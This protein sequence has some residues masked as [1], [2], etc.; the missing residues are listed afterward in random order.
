M[1][2]LLIAPASGK[3]RRVG[4]KHWFNGRTFRFSLLSLLSVAAETPSDV[5]VRIVD[6]QIEKVPWDD[7]FDLVGITCMTAVAPRSYEIAERFRKRGIP[8]VLGGMHPTLCTEEAARH[9]HAVV[10]GDAEGVWP[11]IVADAQAGRLERIYRNPCA[12]D[13]K[14]LKRPPRALL[15]SRRYAT[16]H[17]VQA[18]RGCPH[19]CGFCAV[20]AFHGATQ[21]QRPVE[22]VV[23]EVAEI[24]GR[25]F[26]FADDNLTADREYAR[27]LFEALVPL[28]KRWM[29][30]ST[31]AITEEPGLVRL[32]ARAGCMGM[33]V[34]L[35]SF[36][37]GNLGAV[38]KTCHRV[39]QYRQAVR[40]LHSHGI[41]VEAGIVFGFDGDG[42]GVFARTL[43]L[44]DDLEIDVIQASILTPLPGTG[45]FEDMRD[46]VVDPDWSHYDFHHVVFQPRNLSRDALQAGHDWVTREFY[47]PW[48]ILRRMARHARRP[49][50]WAT[51]P[52]LAAINLAY[53][54]RIIRWQIRGWDPGVCRKPRR[55]PLERGGF[56]LTLGVANGHDM[57]ADLV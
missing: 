1:N 14:G 37:E 19:G 45:H 24:P 6:E 36:C 53:Y 3:W 30:Q 8:V 46:R 50:G 12:P 41:G 54:G 51:L 18:T 17:A 4:Q 2:I 33:F 5:E 7:E 48:R 52:H 29:V 55:V 42:P 10:V 13:L 35:E 43:D 31:L 40:L 47:R 57:R 44:L 9:A 38:N 23:A 22:E 16:V 49:G 15:Q 11:R 25:F 26:M 27:R 32:A 28:R 39:D 21:R 20:S 56:R 34:G